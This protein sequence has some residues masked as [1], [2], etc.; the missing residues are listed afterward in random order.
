MDAVLRNFGADDRREDPVT[1]FYEDFL[2]AYDKQERKRRG[3]YYTPKPVVSYIVRSVH[4]LL[5]SEFGIEDGLASTITWGEMAKRRK[6]LKIPTGTSADSPFVQ[7]L[8]PATG[9]ATFLVT[10]IEVIFETLTA[11][12]TEEGMSKV[13]QIEA[14]N[15]YVPKHL[16]LRLY[17]YELMMAPYAIAHLKIGLKLYETGYRF[18]SDERARVY[19]TNTLE[20][21]QDFSGRFEFAIPA[22]AHEAQEVNMVGRKTLHR[23]HRQSAV[24]D[25]VSKSYRNSTRLGRSLPISRWGANP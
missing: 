1:Y 21:A 12:W 9:T 6:D 11:Q 19:L 17:G 13:Q 23:R 14:W 10:V 25:S 3:V 18:G 5:Q 20:P 2:N 24:L 8:D 22:L 7:I 4:E 15:T 16:L